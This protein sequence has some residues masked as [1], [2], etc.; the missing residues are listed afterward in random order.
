MWLFRRKITTVPVLV[1]V[2]VG[3]RITGTIPIYAEELYYISTAVLLQSKYYR[4]ISS[5]TVVPMPGYAN[6]LVFLKFQLVLLRTSEL[7]FTGIW[8]ILL[9][10]RS[11]TLSALSTALQA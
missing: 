3:R 9:S 4:L 5:R 2:P 10:L 11:T 7:E 6:S 8:P 1:L